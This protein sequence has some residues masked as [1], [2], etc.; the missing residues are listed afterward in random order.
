MTQQDALS[1]AQ[2]LTAYQFKDP[3]LLSI[4]LTH[5]SVADRRV[6]SNERLE[7]L[8]DSVLGLIVCEELFRR[9]PNY[10]EGEL[11]KIKSVVVSRKICAEIADRA[12]L[13]EL[14]FLGKGMTERTRMPLSLRAAVVESIIGAIYLDGGIEAVR[15]F[16]LRHV[17]SFIDEVAG[18]NGHFN[19]KSALQQY[20]Q[21]HL[22][23]TPRY[24]SLDE[25]GPDHSKCFEVCV[26]INGRRFP[27]AWGPSKK[28]AEQKA[29]MLALHELLPKEFPAAPELSPRATAEEQPESAPNFLGGQLD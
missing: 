17:A 19:H 2:E 18:V 14:L 3:S 9:F 16:I 22:S 26:S 5:A 29:A 1:L 20:A 8:G 10:L 11:T 25:Q 28:D 15:P 6:D 4:A 12:G 23:A 13:G 7:F 24:E 27:S 21:Q